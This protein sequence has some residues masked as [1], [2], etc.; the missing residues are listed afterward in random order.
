MTTMIKCPL[1][2]REILDEATRAAVRATLG[3]TNYSKGATHFHATY[4]QPAWSK[5]MRRVTRIGEH[6]FYIEENWGLYGND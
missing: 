6:I 2:S 1:C 4:V 3:D 5:R